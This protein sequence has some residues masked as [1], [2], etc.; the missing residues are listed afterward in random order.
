MARLRSAARR[1]SRAA[2]GYHVSVQPFRRRLSNSYDARP[3]AVARART[4]VARFAAEAGSTEAQVDD[5]R[6]AVSEAVTNA[7]LH[8]YRGDAGRV[9]VTAAITPGEL[10]ILIADDGCGM[11]PR[12]DRPGLGLGLGL[13]AQ[14]CDQLSVV[15]RSPG[16]TELRMRFDIVEAASH[17]S[18]THAA[19]VG[20][21]GAPGIEA[22]VASP[23]QI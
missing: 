9:H 10:W 20:S 6:L 14:V 11:Q 15:P 5:V 23:S 18:D 22:A 17:A 7:V 16:G 4:A 1:I 19:E 3:D 8:G 2:R 21:G 13:I 12:R